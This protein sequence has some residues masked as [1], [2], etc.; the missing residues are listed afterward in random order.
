M[1]VFDFISR[2]VIFS[3]ANDSASFF[4]AVH[5]FRRLGVLRVVRRVV[6]ACCAESPRGSGSA[7]TPASTFCFRRFCVHA[8]VC[9]YVCV[10]VR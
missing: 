5:R 9:V 7:Y 4:D 3:R 1:F 10:Q 2:V 8:C 6:L